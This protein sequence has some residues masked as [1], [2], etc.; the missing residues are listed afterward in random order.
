M[1]K[2]NF[3]DDFDQVLAKRQREQRFKD[4]LRDAVDEIIEE[5]ETA[6][7]RTPRTD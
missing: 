4:R 5:K 1:K 3:W 7:G 2:R 6:N